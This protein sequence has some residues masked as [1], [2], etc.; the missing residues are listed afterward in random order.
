MSR[1]SHPDASCAPRQPPQGIRARCRVAALALALAASGAAALDSDR[2]KPA[3]IEADRVEIDRPAGESRYYGNVVFEQG[4][5][6]ITGD[7]MKLQAPGGAVEHAEVHG[8]RATIRQQ[9]EA[10]D[11]VH[12]RAQHIIYEVSDGLITLIDNAELERAGDRFTAARIE[13]R[14]NTGR[15]DASRGDEDGK[16]VRIRIEPQNDG[17]GSGD[18]TSDDAGDSP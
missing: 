14:P 16:R 1:R 13:Y 7:R 10:G 2:R 11:I 17:A 5:L 15:I 8:E 9:T 4:T 18:S 12:A 3:S 6:R